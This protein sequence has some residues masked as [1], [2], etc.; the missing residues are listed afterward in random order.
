MFFLAK[1][2]YYV[3]NINL[4]LLTTCTE[5][6][7]CRSYFDG[8]ALGSSDF[9]LNIIFKSKNLDIKIINLGRN[10]PLTNFG[11]LH[12]ITPEENLSKAE[13]NIL[14]YFDGRL[15]VSPDKIFQVLLAAVDK[16]LSDKIQYKGKTYELSRSVFNPVVLSV[17]EGGNLVFEIDLVPAFRMDIDNFPVR[18]AT[19]ENLLSFCKNFDIEL[20][21]FLAIALRNVDNIE[22]RFEIDFHDLERDIMH[23]KECAKKVIRLL[24]HLRNETGGQA[25]KIKSFII[26]VV[27][28][29]EILRRPE[30]YWNNKNLEICF[31][32]CLEA[33]KDG[34]KE[35]SITDIFYPKVRKNYVNF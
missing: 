30:N 31:I 20:R 24:K 32:D 27:V 29:K 23:K 35:K 25:K 34:L 12:V 18:S 33:L 6:S 19:K 5:I 3:F 21:T 11:H 26:K 4:K 9:D 10:D 14:K 22:G 13:K 7:Y 2:K 15:C 16:S 17:K 8:L 28:M 1:T